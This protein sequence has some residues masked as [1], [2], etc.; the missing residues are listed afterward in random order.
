[1]EDKQ[2]PFLSLTHEEQGERVQRELR[3]RIEF[4]EKRAAAKAAA[5]EQQQSDES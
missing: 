1:M 2:K 3:E 5:R 4:Y